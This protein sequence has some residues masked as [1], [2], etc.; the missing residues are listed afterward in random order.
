MSYGHSI[1]PDGSNHWVAHLAPAK[2]PQQFEARQ[3][4]APVGSQGSG[5]FSAEALA[6]AKA[7]ANP[8]QIAPRP[9]AKAMP[10]LSSIVATCPTCKHP[11][12][13]TKTGRKGVRFC[14]NCAGYKLLAPDEMRAGFIRQMRPEDR[15]RW[16]RLN[17]ENDLDERTGQ[18]RRRPVEVIDLDGDEMPRKR[19][20]MPGAQ[21]SSGSTGGKE[22]S[23]M[24]VKQEIK[25]EEEISD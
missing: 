16:G 25:L 17:E 1:R 22:F 3:I 10:V 9:K 6:R 15:E 7:L 23:F 2:F 20:P 13:K 11:T 21:S 14:E 19:A 12:I 5:L 8:S 4:A 18:K 24:S